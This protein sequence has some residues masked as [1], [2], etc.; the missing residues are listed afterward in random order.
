MVI[1]RGVVIALAV[2]F[3]AS[4]LGKY[5]IDQMPTVFRAT[6][7]VEVLPLAGQDVGALDTAAELEIVRSPLVLQPVIDD[8]GLTGTWAKRIFGVEPRQLATGEVLGYMNRILTVK[9]HGGTN[10]MEIT[11]SSNLPEEAAAIANAVMRSYKSKRDAE[12]LQIVE[13]RDPHT[14]SERRQIGAAEQG[15]E[16]RRTDLEALRVRLDAKGIQ[17]DSASVDPTDPDLQNYRSGVRDLDERR[18]E[19]E[20]L[21]AQL[22]QND[23]PSSVNPSV[24]IITRAVAPRVASSPNRKL[25]YLITNVIAAF[26]SI[27]IAS[28][29]E[30]IFLLLRAAERPES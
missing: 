2:F 19:L 22:T 30:V 24:K 5:I 7:Q 26:L 28:S 23:D 14:V 27:G 6:S 9:F 11:A 3:G 20:K 12:Q 21:K 1:A 15:I 10:L 17:L 13:S 16:S 29:A 18:H 25:Y 8:L 4:S